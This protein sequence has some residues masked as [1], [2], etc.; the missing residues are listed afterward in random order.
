MMKRQE[1]NERM[2]VDFYAAAA[3]RV[4]S[5]VLGQ[6]KTVLMLDTISIFICAVSNTQ[7]YKA[8]SEIP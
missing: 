2:V 4:G 8:G 6:D 3:H 1:N 5:V 7:L